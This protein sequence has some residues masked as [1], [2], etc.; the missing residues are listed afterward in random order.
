MKRYAHVKQIINVIANVKLVCKKIANAQIKCV[1]KN[2]VILVSMHV[3]TIAAGRNVIFIKNVKLDVKKFSV[4][5][6]MKNTIAEVITVVL[7][8]VDIAHKLV[9]NCNF[10]LM[11][12]MYVLS[13]F[14]LKSAYYVKSNVLD[15]IIMMNR[16]KKFWLWLKIHQ[17]KK[18]NSILKNCIYVGRI[19]LVDSFVR[20]LVYVRTL[21]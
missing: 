21:I 4:M 6:Q 5:M 15:F 8:I 19:I 7:R 17:L 9:R 18:I 1:N 16:L 12:F 14:V 3:V 13:N 10:N 20:T 11:K 2:Q